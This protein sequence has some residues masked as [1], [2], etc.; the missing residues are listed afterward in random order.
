MLQIVFKVFQ[1]KFT[2]SLLPFNQS[3][4]IF[5]GRLTSCH[6]RVLSICQVCRTTRVV[7]KHHMSLRCLSYCFLH[8]YWNHLISLCKVLYTE[9]LLLFSCHV[10]NRL[11]LLTA[12]LRAWQ[13]DK[14]NVS[15]LRKFIRVFL[16]P[17]HDT[18]SFN[19]RHSQCSHLLISNSH[20]YNLL[21]NCALPC[22][23]H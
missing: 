13:L 21:V 23:Y 18:I 6:H 17:F 3:L 7:N 11:F 9:L 16:V 5:H 4:V 8:W 10:K 12:S 22:Q 1:S 2:Y 19:E 14:L 20:Y 15:Y